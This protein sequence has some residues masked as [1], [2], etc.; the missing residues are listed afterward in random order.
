MSSFCSSLHIELQQRGVEFTKLFGKYSNLSSALL[1]RMPP[2]EVARQ[3]DI[4]TNGDVDQNDVKNIDDS[5]QHVSRESVSKE[6]IIFN[7][8][9][10][11]LIVFYF[12]NSLLDLLGGGDISDIDI[13]KPN[14]ISIQPALTNSNNQDLLDL[15]GGLDTSP[16]LPVAN[17]SLSL[18]SENNNGMLPFTNNQNSNFLTGDLLNTNI[19]VNG[20]SR[21]KAELN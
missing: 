16:S 8:V 17:T 20:E 12:Q 13:I 1:E 10:L 15:L 3:N 18:I 4:Q 6:F 21:Q 11:Y 2:M 9:L 7:A 19:I 14:S 5:P